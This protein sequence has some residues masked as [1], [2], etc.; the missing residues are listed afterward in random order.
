M[1]S[2]Y[3]V[4]KNTCVIKQGNKEIVTDTNNVSGN[5]YYCNN[6]NLAL[7]EDENNT[8]LNAEVIAKD[9]ILKAEVEAKVKA[10]E[11]VRRAEAA[12]EELLCEARE[13]V[14]AI[15]NEGYDQGY[16]NGE[17]QG[18]KDAYERTLI[19]AKQ[20]AVVIINDASNILFNA[21]SEYEDYIEKKKDEIILLSINMAEAVLKK[22]LSLETGLDEIISEVLHNSRNVQTFIIKT[23]SLYVEE[24]KAKSLYWKESFGLKSEIFVIADESVGDGNAVI[25]KSNGK[26]EIGLGSGMEGIRQALL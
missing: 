5:T 22:E 14:E 13:S 15:R 12:A 23:S 2:S 16:K 8:I 4:I 21:K 17:T 7:S 20:E 3:N 9:I 24:I 11:L 18:Y 1:Q 6:E 19:S 10:E 25:E 26:V